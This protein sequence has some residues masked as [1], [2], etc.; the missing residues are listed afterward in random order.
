[1]K[2]KTTSEGKTN[3]QEQTSIEDQIKIN[4]DQTPLP[5]H[6]IRRSSSVQPLIFELKHPFIFDIISGNHDIT[7]RDAYWSWVREGLLAKYENNYIFVF[8]KE[9]EWTDRKRS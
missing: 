8:I 7:L 2:Y 9:M 6:K 4:H 5:T 3:M 1:M